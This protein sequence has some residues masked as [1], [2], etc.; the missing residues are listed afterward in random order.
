[1]DQRRF[2]LFIALSSIIIFGWPL[3]MNKFFPRPKTDPVAEKTLK[4]PDANKKVA[5]K[6]EGKKDATV[7]PRK[8]INPE[9]TA[10]GKQLEKG[11][12]KAPAK[13][14]EKPAEKPEV[15]VV[16]GQEFKSE[17]VTLGSID[18]KSGYRLL[19]N[20]T[21]LGG[22]IDTIE[23][24]DPRYRDVEKS[25]PPLKI[26]SPGSGKE[27]TFQTSIIGLGLEDLATRNW[28][29]ITREEAAFRIKSADGKVL[30]TKKYTV[31]KKDESSDVPDMRAYVVLCEINFENTSDKERTLK[32][33]LQG[34]IGLP[35]ENV[36][37]TQKFRDVVAGFLN[38]D[39]SV[40]QQVLP[41]KALVEAIDGNKVEEWKKPLKYIGDD[42]Q[43]FAALLFPLGDQLKE[44]Y[45]ESVHGM[46]SG[47]LPTEQKE[48]ADVSV[49]LSSREIPV[50]A[51]K[52]NTAG[53]IKHSFELYTGPKRDELVTPLGAHQVIDYGWFGFVSRPMLAMLKFFYLMFGNYGIAIICLTVVVRGCMF[54]LSIKQ[55]RSAAKMQELQPEL[56]A[57]KEKY[58][59]QKEKFAKA[60]ME[61]FSKH[62]YNP[63]GGCLLVFLQLPIFIGLYNALNHA[64]DLRLAKF[65]WVDNLA[66]PD[67]L[68]HLPF[69]VPFFGWTEFN[70]LPMIT[71]VLYLV[72]QKMLMPPA[73][74]EEQKMQQKMMNFMMVF[75]GAMFYRV[76]AG[77]CVYFIASSLWGLAE[78]KLLPK[79]SPK[80]ALPPE[81][82]NDS[83]RKP[84]QGPR[85][86]APPSNGEGFMARL[87]RA[88]EKDVALKR[89]GQEKRK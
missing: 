87:L 33:E 30:V 3:M 21:N 55:A 28:E 76:P 67:A 59:N 9:F 58:T 69:R 65:L 24:N 51:A 78:R 13:E 16:K 2:I 41:A 80:K 50:P 36:D 11:V 44:P 39:G 46:V 73:I 42:V 57:L 63:F 66:A 38:E 85:S 84:P 45:F 43:Y 86:D 15:P 56:T 27:L 18:P 1:M 10:T 22:S 64:V 47:K 34:P 53:S 7:D 52:D 77:L 26:L 48:R 70:L 88:A 81:T 12:E 89:A 54:P 29:V 74:N 6:A 75:M 37:N 5:D 31:Q 62:N 19:V 4:K 35:L 79:L 23:F 82:G 49:V 25:H 68:F 40:N 14:G 61:L 17:R 72:Q 71:V 20:T 60:Q 83:D 32:Y 8:P